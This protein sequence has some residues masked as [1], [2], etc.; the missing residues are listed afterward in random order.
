LGGILGL[1]QQDAVSFLQAGS[2]AVVGNAAIGGPLEPAQIDAL[3]AD[4]TAARKV[5]NFAEA[6]RIRKELL[7]AGIVLEDTPQGTEWR[8]E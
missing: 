3:I 7:A 6:D 5:R 4:R 1:L 2:G 8:R